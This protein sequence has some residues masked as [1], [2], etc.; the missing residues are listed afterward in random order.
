MLQGEIKTLSEQAETNLETL[1]QLRAQNLKLEAQII[2]S[3]DCDEKKV[4]SH[5]MQWEMTMEDL[6]RELKEAQATIV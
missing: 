1:K 3:R 5:R 2:E 4:Q 6:N